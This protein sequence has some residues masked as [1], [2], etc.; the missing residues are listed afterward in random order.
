MMAELGPIAAPAHSTPA[1]PLFPGLTPAALA[2]VSGRRPVAAVAVRRRRQLDQSEVAEIDVEFDDDGPGAAHDDSD[3]PGR[4][5]PGRR[6]RVIRVFGKCMSLPALRA[7]LKKPDSK[8]RVSAASFANEAAFLSA[9][10]GPPGGRQHAALLAG[11]GALCKA[12][13]QQ[14]N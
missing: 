11:E 4:S 6:R 7:R 14:S 10:V 13:Q 3:G 2:A 8:W 1:L 9:A 5:R 12:K